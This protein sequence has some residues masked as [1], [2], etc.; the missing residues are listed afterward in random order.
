MCLHCFRIWKLVWGSVQRTAWYGYHSRIR[1]YLL[2][3]TKHCWAVVCQLLFLLLT[4]RKDLRDGSVITWRGCRERAGGEGPSG[5]TFTVLPTGELFSPATW[6]LLHAA[7]ICLRGN[8]MRLMS[9][10]ADDPQS[11]LRR[12]QYHL[13]H[14]CGEFVT[15]PV[16]THSSALLQRK[17]NPTEMLLR[18]TS[19]QSHRQRTKQGRRALGG[20]APEWT[21]IP[22][23]SSGQTPTISQQFYCFSRD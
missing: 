14:G 15:C 6:M 19:D 17:Q 1:L 9:G 18:C 21:E 5:M 8:T 3:A 2:A 11:L 12:N 7:A 23:M 22:L 13:Q 20:K 4:W 10:A 16:S